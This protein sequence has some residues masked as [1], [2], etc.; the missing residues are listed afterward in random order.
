M[1]VTITMRDETTAGDKIHELTLSLLTEQVTVRELIRSRVYQE[2]KDHNVRGAL[3][4]FNG[5]VAPSDSERQQN[6]FRLREP[7][8]IDWKK[9]FETA[10]EAFQRNGF[11]VLVDRQQVVDLDEEVLLRPGSEVSF[12]KLIPLVGG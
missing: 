12:L 1:P 3:S 9:Q 4:V 5:L 6:G 8:Q 7:R 10:V 2:V 11:I